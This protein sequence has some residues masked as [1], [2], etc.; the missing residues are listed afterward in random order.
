MGEAMVIPNIHEFEKPVVTVD[1]VIFSIIKGKLHI[2]LVKRKEEPSKG[3]WALP[4]GFVK[5]QES[6]EEAAKRKLLE[7]TGVKD[8][9]LE[10]LYTWGDVNRDSRGRVITVSY[11]ALV[12]AQDK[13]MQLSDE[14]A[15]WTLVNT[16]LR[17]P[18]DHSKIVNYA[19]KRL[20]WKFEYTPVAFS[21]LPKT[22]KL[23]ELKG[24]YD[25]VFEKDFDKRNFIKKILSLKI[26]EEAGK[27]ESVANRP[28]KLY[29]AKENISPIIGIV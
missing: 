16:N 10:Q 28:A 29:R 17:L 25:T 5:I 19:L 27:E 22:F 14:G 23:S 24:L 2:L 26:L 18:F 13:N 7:K 3:E 11:Y 4:G 1:I 20:R 9:Y 6:L 12:N 8:L 21:L 15:K